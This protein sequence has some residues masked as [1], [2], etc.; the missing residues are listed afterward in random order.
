MCVKCLFVINA[1]VY[2]CS[3]TCYMYIIL[4][5]ILAFYVNFI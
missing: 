4:F 2:I 1:N 5:K 3:Y